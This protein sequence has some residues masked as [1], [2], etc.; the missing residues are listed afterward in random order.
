MNTGLVE[1]Y[2][3]MRSKSAKRQHKSD[4]FTVF[5]A[6][7]IMHIVLA[8]TNSNLHPAFVYFFVLFAFSLYRCVGLIHFFFAVSSSSFTPSARLFS[9]SSHSNFLFCTQICTLKNAPFALI[10]CEK[11]ILVDSVYPKMGR[12]IFGFVVA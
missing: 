4:C 2:T 10:E 1:Q 6:T 5:V 8:R 7:H 12:R 11:R 9:F 3:T